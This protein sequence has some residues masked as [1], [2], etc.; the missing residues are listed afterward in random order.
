MEYRLGLEAVSAFQY[1]GAPVEMCEFPDEHHV[2]WHP[3]HRLAIYER[4]LDWFDFWL[5]GKAS[6]EPKR[7][8]EIRR[9]EA[10]RR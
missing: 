9:W 3:A 10:M 1:A 5:Q 7:R 2:K 8:N 4:N 6:S